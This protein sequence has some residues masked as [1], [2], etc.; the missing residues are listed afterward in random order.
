MYQKDLLV[1]GL[2]EPRQAKNRKRSSGNK[3]FGLLASFKTLRLKDKTLD[4]RLVLSLNVN[5]W[6]VLGYFSKF[7]ISY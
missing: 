4:T 7:L 6:L 3:S 5:R 2:N 1:H